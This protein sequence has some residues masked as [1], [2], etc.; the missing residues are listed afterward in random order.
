MNTLYNCLLVSLIYS[1]LPFFFHFFLRQRYCN[2]V[3]TLYVLR[4]FIGLIMIIGLVGNVIV[5]AVITTLRKRGQ[6]ASV[7]L[8][9][10]HLAISDLMVCLLCIPLTIFTNFNYP[11]EFYERDV[12]LC[13]I[14]R[15]MQVLELLL[16][17]SQFEISTPPPPPIPL[18]HFPPFPENSRGYWDSNLYVSVNSNSRPFPLLPPKPHAG[19]ETPLCTGQIELS[20]TLAPSP[21]PPNPL[22]AP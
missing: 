14:S 15:F 19:P 12:G 9:F 10:L 17:I 5:V 3:Y 16:C 13:K 20:S 4:S 7:Q 8:F 6:K 21:R 22:L 11:T 1:Y 2:E 18:P